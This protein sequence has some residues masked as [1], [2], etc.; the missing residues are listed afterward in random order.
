MRKDQE[1]KKCSP[2]VYLPHLEGVFGMVRTYVWSF[3]SLIFKTLGA[4][5]SVVGY[6]NF[7]QMPL[8]LR[9]LWAPAVERLGTFRQVVLGSLL[10]SSLCGIAI[11]GCVLMGVTN[12][13]IIASLFLVMVIVVSV[14]DI[15][16]MGYKMSV[17]ATAEIEYFVPIGNGFFRLGGMFASTVLVYH[18]FVESS[19]FDPRQ[20]TQRCDTGGGRLFL[21]I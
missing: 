6:I 18:R 7:L 10:L 21:A 19:W 9:A 1:Q 20:R 15:S 2:W 16:Y 17:L 8:S 11:G 12:L 3:S 13:W 4:R 14:L 5:S